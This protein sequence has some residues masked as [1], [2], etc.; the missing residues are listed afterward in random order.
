MSDDA[1]K[2]NV[3]EGRFRQADREVSNKK[4]LKRG[5]GDGTSDGMEARVA[6]LEAGVSHL[7][8]DVGELRSD[9]RDV[10]ERLISVEA[11]MATK[12]FVVASLLLLLTAIA[13][14]TVFQ[15]QVQTWLG[16]IPKV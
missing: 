4:N 1:S 13:A 10:R 3:L 15:G 9:M 11:N 14:L 7:E 2:S 16:V 5:D 6:R 12:G 8:R